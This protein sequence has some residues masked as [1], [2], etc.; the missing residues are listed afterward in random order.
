MLKT[1]S[2]TVSLL[3][4]SVPFLRKTSA[5][6][7]IVV[8]I[9]TPA[10]IRLALEQMPVEI[11]DNN[12]T[13]EVFGIEHA[14]TFQTIE[15]A[16][17][18]DRVIYKGKPLNMTDSLTCL[19]VN[20]YSESRNQDDIGKAGVGY[21]TLN[22]V[23]M[24]G[25]RT[26]CEAVLNSRY[27]IDNGLLRP[28]TNLCHFSWWC[29]KRKVVHITEEKAYDKALKIAKG[30]IAR[31]IPNPI[32]NRDHYCTLAVEPTTYWVSDMKPTSRLVHGEHVWFESGY[33]KDPNYAL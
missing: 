27:V 17:Y 3:R 5:E 2:L 26:I 1:L 32:G 33:Y 11:Y 28:Q 6:V 21:A 18:L 13:V 30:V 31:E 14:P 23:G 29:D 7:L 4:Y 15:L 16:R 22:R 8:L 10:M 20:I 25:N 24:F 19:A 12:S 9:L